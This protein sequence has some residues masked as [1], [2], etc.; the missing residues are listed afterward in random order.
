M[1]TVPAA[2][3]VHPVLTVSADGLPN[4]GILLPPPP[5]EDPLPYPDGWIRPEPDPDTPV[6]APVG[7][8]LVDFAVCPQLF[9]DAEILCLRRDSDAPSLL[10]TIF[11]P[12]RSSE[13]NTTR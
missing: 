11:Q 5:R 13:R 2:S 7:V 8:D 9:A 4:C 10:H 3:S 6:Y 1:S 12:F